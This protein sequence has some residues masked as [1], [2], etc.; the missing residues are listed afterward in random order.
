METMKAIVHYEYGGPDVLKYVDVEKP[1]PKAN[2]VLVKI[3][4][5]TVNRTD[6]G[7]RTAE[8][9]ISRL[10]SGLRKPKRPIL[11]SEFSGIVEAVGK[12]VSSYKVG[13]R[14]FGLSTYKFG[15]HA[16]Y[17]CI[18]ENGSMAIMPE[19]IGFEE[20]ACVLDGLMLA[21][22]YIRKI[23]FHK[24]PKIMINGAT[25]SIGIACL[26]LA[27]YH[28]A[29]VTAVGNTQNL[30]LLKSLGA[31][32]VI[33]Y[34]TTDFT[35]DEEQYDFVIDAVGKST[36]FKSKKLLKP[37]GVYFSTE[38]GPYGQNVYLPLFTFF[39]TGKKI[40]FP[41]PTDNKELIA[42]F[43]QILLSGKYKAIIDRSYTLAETAEAH[44]YVDLG[45]KTGNVLIKI[46]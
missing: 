33:D 8:Y 28:G 23:D 20:A 12:E 22:N 15:T 9:F 17:I 3:M 11:G 21:Q 2:E 40:K 24:A 1:I 7:F 32:R 35:N 42:Y 34:T 44:R 46:A 10:F 16:E 30:D 45:Q 4:A 14:V 43:K 27:K 39:S 36:F 31:D 37:K 6:T 25:G 26:Q 18:K 5:S 38:L 13:D 29:Q 41:I 19:N